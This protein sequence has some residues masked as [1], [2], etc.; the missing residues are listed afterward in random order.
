MLFLF[1]MKKYIISFFLLLTA[2]QLILAVDL[3]V[4]KLSSNEV[5]ILGAD[6]PAVFN[7]DIT[8]N[9][10]TDSFIIYTFFGSGYSP[11]E[12]FTILQHKTKNIQFKVSPPYDLSRTGANA[13]DY[14]I[15]GKDGTKYTGRLNVQVIE[16]KDA[17]EIGSNE[18][19]PETSSIE[20]Y[21]KNKVNL[22]FE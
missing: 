4:E 2:T 13:F 5:M 1:K 21:I 12:E 10:E 7:L 22:D 11:R 3:N 19:N 8:N 16:L 20:I 9:G 14:Y 6:E 17:F 15:Q 18:I